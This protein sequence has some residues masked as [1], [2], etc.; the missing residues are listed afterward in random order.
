[1]IGENIRV[2]GIVQGVGFRPTVWR[3]ARECGLVGQVWNDAAGVTIHAWGKQ[4]MLDA[5]VQR[6]QARQPPLAHIDAIIRS[7]LNEATEVP[8]DFRIVTSQVG[9]VRTGVAADAATCP[10]CLA[11]L[12]DPANR[13]Y[14]YPFTNCTHC[15]PRLSIVKAIPYDRANTSMAAF[16]MCAQCQAEYTEPD[17]RRFHAQPNACADCGPQVWLED[18][19]GRRLAPNDDSDAIATAARLIRQGNILAVKGLGGIHLACDA[20]SVAAVDTLRRRKRRYHK[21]F[22]MMARDI[23]MVARFAEANAAE[24]ALLRDKAAPLVVLNAAGESLAGGIAPGQNTLGFMLPYTPLHHLLMQD[25]T[26]PIVLTSGNRSDEP[27][28]ITNRDAHQRLEQIA[29]Y[30]LLHDRDIV[31]RLDDSVLRLV[32]GEP[33]MLRR[34]RGYAPLPIRL[35]EGF[36]DADH[37]LAMGGELKNTF[38]LLQEGR[39]ILSQ[40]MGDLEDAATY[41]DYRHNLQLYRQLFEFRPGLIAV[42]MH[43]GYL[44]TQLGR[45]IAA[46]EGLQLIKVQHHHAHIA[47]CM[48]EHGLASVSYTHLTLPTSCVQCRCRWWGVDF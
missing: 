31:N 26:R 16:P 4:Q 10:E 3:L 9:E 8:K 40:H 48:A 29:D 19:E 36:A 24:K 6:L 41:Q 28:T 37:I 12:Q 7:A 2:T 11:E 1:M 15:G 34:A 33:R 44:S 17:N 42:D 21:A 35:P 25:M 39:A 30:Y 18:A 45:R 20:G 5:F 47:G 32:S 14:R 46:E 43:P 38:C 27:Q 13:R 22:A 23:Q